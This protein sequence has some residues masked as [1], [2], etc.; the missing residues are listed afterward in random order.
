[1]LGKAD[2]VGI[3]VGRRDHLDVDVLTVGFPH[4]MTTHESRMEA[5]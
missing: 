2:V 3:L 4:G 1:M 5:R